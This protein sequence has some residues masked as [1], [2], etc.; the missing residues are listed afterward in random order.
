M[1]AADL[2]WPRA[3]TNKSNLQ[4]LS[5]VKNVA[6]TKLST[7]LKQPDNFSSL[8]NSHNLRLGA[9]GSQATV[10]RLLIQYRDLCVLRLS[11]PPD[12]GRAERV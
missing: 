8:S 12:A 7:L 5:E 11:S 9:V 4:K 2:S 1:V 10:R 3:Q 6:P